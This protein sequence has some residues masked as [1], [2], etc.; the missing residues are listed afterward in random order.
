MTSRDDWIGYGWL[1]SH[2][3]E[4]QSDAH[5]VEGQWIVEFWWPGWAGLPCEVA[6]EKWALVEASEIT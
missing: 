1:T 4:S 2:P 6:V 5:R 3:A